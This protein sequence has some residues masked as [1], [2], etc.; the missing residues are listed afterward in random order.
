MVLNV[1]LPSGGG[2]AVPHASGR[3]N[4]HLAYALTTW[5]AFFVVTA[6]TRI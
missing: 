1:L 6:L 2:R 3:V 4:A 5:S